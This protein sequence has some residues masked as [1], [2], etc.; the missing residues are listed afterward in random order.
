MVNDRCQ[1]VRAQLGWLLRGEA[2]T[3]ELAGAFSHLAECSGC[4]AEFEAEM[5]LGRRLRAETAR[6]A[7]PPEVRA[8]VEKLFS[9]RES[10][11]AVWKE[12]VQILFRRPLI[13]AALGAAAALLFVVPAYRV[14]SRSQAPNAL[15]VLA[16]E[17][18]SSH[19]WMVLQRDLLD[20]EKADAERAV[21][22]LHDRLGLPVKTAFRGDQEVRLLTARPV[23]VGGRAGVT[24]VYAEGPDRLLTLTLLPGREIEMPRE[25]T[26]QIESYR[27]F[28]TQKDSIGV[29]LW[30]QADIAYALTTPA[31]G[32]DL[33]RLF[34]KVRKAKPQ[35]A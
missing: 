4:R 8:A 11:W 12:R 21:A 5:A 26:T 28:V 34:L 16:A 29:V 10:P 23:L 31:S 22:L 14:V 27:P 3:T 2:E 30:K 7:V 13:A 20:R 1:D 32:E 19:R 33:F 15:E 24:L 17:A 18:A 9:R 6:Y 25:G 35:G